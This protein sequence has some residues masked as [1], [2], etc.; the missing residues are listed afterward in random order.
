[1]DTADLNYLCIRQP[2]RQPNNKHKVMLDNTDICEMFTV[3]YYLLLALL[4]FLS[5]LSLEVGHV[6]SRKRSKICGVL[7]V[8]FPTSRTQPILIRPD[9]VPAETADL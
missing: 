3:Q 2:R 8:C 1:M 7:W 5:L 6:L 9:S 4:I